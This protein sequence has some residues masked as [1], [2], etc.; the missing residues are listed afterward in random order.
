VRG[1]ELNPREDRAHRSLGHTERVNV[2]QRHVDIVAVFGVVFGETGKPRS[3]KA[4][5]EAGNLKRRPASVAP[6]RL[7][8][9]G[10]DDMAAAA[11]CHRGLWTLPDAV[12]GSR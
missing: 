11:L 6:K 8:A 10:A 4:R 1:G 12:S 3:V 7:H 5:L 9:F 2:D